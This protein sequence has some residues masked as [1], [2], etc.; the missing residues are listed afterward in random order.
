MSYS[1]FLSACDLIERNSESSDFV[2]PRK[3]EIVAEAE[4][5][6]QTVFPRSYREFLLR[7][8]CGDIAG[9]EFYGVL[10]ADFEN[11]GV[12]D[13]VWLTVR[14]RTDS[15]LRGSLVIV[16]ALGEGS[17]SCIDCAQKNSDGESPVVVWPLGGPAPGAKLELEA[18]DFGAFLLS[19]VRL[20]TT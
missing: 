12:P 19:K 11:S 6:L 8:G 17:Y 14:E 4:R 3:P 2:G 5:V 16:Y 18:A 1:D 15:Q 10:T 20:F 13:A 9:A 7:Y